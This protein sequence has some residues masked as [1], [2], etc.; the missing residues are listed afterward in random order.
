MKIK[1]CLGGF[2]CF[3]KEVL[4]AIDLDKFISKGFIFQIEFLYR[5]FKKGFSVHEIPITFYARISGLS[6]NQK[7]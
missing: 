6:K 4:E 3:R 7:E 5:A 1:D 2:K